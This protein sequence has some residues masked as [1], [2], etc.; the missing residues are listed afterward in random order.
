MKSLIAVLIYQLAIAFLIVVG[1]LP[2]PYHVLAFMVP[3]VFIFVVPI[4][5]TFP[6]FW[7][8]GGPVADLMK[9]ARVPLRSLLDRPWVWAFHIPKGD[10]P[11]EEECLIA[12]RQLIQYWMAMLVSACGMFAALFADYGY[13]FWWGGHDH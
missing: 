11:T 7:E 8:K 2:R 4:I 3:L 12:K 1:D 5:A 9:R 6:D 10:N 13:T